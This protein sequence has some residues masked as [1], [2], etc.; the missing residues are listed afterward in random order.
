[1]D[2]WIR[3]TSA[4]YFEWAMTNINDILYISMPAS[5]FFPMHQIS[6]RQW[7]CTLVIL[8]DWI[9]FSMINGK[10]NKRRNEM[11]FCSIHWSFFFLI[12]EPVLHVYFYLYCGRLCATHINLTQMGAMMLFWVFWLHRKTPFVC[13][14]RKL[15][16]NLSWITIIIIM[17][18][19]FIFNMH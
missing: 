1:M 19:K 15:K 18:Y 13:H 12:W 14:R 10:Y 2:K 17:I 3:V 16:K 7:G 6:P 11:L 5:Y 4:R 9:I 8:V